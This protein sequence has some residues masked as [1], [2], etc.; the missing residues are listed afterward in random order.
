MSSDITTFLGKQVSYTSCRDLKSRAPDIAH[1]L[2][3]GSIYGSGIIKGSLAA[4]G[5]SI[6][7]KATGGGVPSMKDGGVTAALQSIGDYGSVK[8]DAARSIHDALV[9]GGIKGRD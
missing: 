4:E 5:M 1:G 3:Y 8:S 9:R 7:A 6:E 2:G